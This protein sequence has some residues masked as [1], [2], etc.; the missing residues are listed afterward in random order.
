MNIT[1]QERSD[2]I[3]LVQLEVI[4]SGLS[5][6]DTHKGELGHRGIRF[7][8][9]H[10]M[11]LAATLGY[12]TNFGPESL[13]AKTYIQCRSFMFGGR[14]TRSQDCYVELRFLFCMAGIL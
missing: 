1:V 12:D 5:E 10:P 11:H 6:H 14:L 7:S 9:V 13:S 2:D 3:H 8:I 4:D